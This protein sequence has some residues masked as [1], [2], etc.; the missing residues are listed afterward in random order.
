[1]A[2]KTWLKTWLI[3]VASLRVLSVVFGYLMLDKIKDNVF[4]SA[5][6][7]EGEMIGQL[8]NMRRAPPPMGC[9]WGAYAA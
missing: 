4:T 7:S 9:L 1:M 8:H 6:S 5:P 2:N 3:F